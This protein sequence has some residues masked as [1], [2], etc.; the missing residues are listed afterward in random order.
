MARLTELHGLR[1]FLDTNVVVYIVEGFEPFGPVL[2]AL[3]GAM[4]SG[5]VTAVTS[6]L[7][8]AEALVKPIADGRADLAAAYEA[9]V[10]RGLN[11][12]IVALSRAVLREAARVRASTRLKLPDAIQVAAAVEAKCD[13]F[14]TR[15]EDIRRSTIPVVLL[16]SLSI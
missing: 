8:L 11:R 6:E 1:V 5:H 7:T 3:L 9:F 10:S 4:D 15:D 13:V 16:G 2:R 14:L 12:E